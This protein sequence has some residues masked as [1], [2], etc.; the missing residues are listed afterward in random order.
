MNVQLDCVRVFSVSIDDEFSFILAS[1]YFKKFQKIV[2]YLFILRKSAEMNQK[3]LNMFKKKALKFK[4]QSDQLFRRNSKNVLLR[5]IIDDLK[6]QQL[7]L[8]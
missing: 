8:K 4:L 2:V 7:I 6:E 3:E 1:D 5:R